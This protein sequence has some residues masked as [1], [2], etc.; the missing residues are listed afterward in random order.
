MCNIVTVYFTS[1]MQNEN[2]SHQKYELLPPL[3]ASNLVTIILV[4]I[5]NTQMTYSHNIV[6]DD[7]VREYK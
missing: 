1:E 7:N 4:S 2:N 5:I 6:G 3:T